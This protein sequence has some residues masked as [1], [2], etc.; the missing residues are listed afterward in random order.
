MENTQQ[1]PVLGN[2]GLARKAALGE[3][4]LPEELLEYGKTTSMYEIFR[5]PSSDLYAFKAAI[6]DI[7]FKGVDFWIF[8]YPDKSTRSIMYKIIDNNTLGQIL[9]D[10]GGAPEFINAAKTKDNKNELRINHRLINALPTETIIKFPLVGEPDY[11]EYERLTP[12]ETRASELFGKRQARI[13][14]DV[15]QYIRKNPRPFIKR[16]HKMYGDRFDLGLTF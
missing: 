7:G 12:T 11:K 13:D 4:T 8:A 1:N 5:N 9:L 10:A 15:L 16:L 2:M 6:L 14:P 3:K